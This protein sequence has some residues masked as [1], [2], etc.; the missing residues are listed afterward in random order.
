M[1]SRKAARAICELPEL[2]GNYLQKIKWLIIGTLIKRDVSIII[3]RKSLD[4]LQNAGL[5]N[6]IYFSTE[7]DS[8]STNI[9]S[10]SKADITH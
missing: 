10:I 8:G 3:S 7:I 6:I 1:V 4:P 5:A 2:V 9:I